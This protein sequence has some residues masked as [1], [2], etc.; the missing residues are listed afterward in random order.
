MALKRHNTLLIRQF[1]SAEVESSRQAPPM[2]LSRPG[3]AGDGTVADTG[4]P[5]KPVV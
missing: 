3:L 4:P 2:R 1:R 5:I